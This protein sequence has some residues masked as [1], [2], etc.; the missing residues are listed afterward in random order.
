MF[1]ILDKN[2]NECFDD[3][4]SNKLKCIIDNFKTSVDQLEVICH[5]HFADIRR[6]ID[7]RR[8]TLL[9]KINRISDEMIKR[10]EQR[11]NNVKKSLTDNQL[12]D[13]NFD[14]DKENDLIE[15]YTLYCDEK[16]KELR[17]KVKSLELIK[18]NLTNDTF[19]VTHSFEKDSFGVLKLSERY[20]NLIGFSTNGANIDIWS[21]GTNSVIK[22][23]PTFT[24]EVMCLCVHDKSKLV[25]G[26]Y[27]R[28]I[29]IWDLHTGEHVKSL[30]G[31]LEQ[32]RC[33]NVLKS[34]LLASGSA[35]STIKIWNMLNMTCMHTLKGW[36]ECLEDL[37]NGQLASGSTELFV[38]IWNLGDG[39]CVR[40][41]KMYS[42]AVNCLKCLHEDR[43]AVGSWQLVLVWNYIT[44]ER[45]LTLNA[46]SDSVYGFEVFF[47]RLISCSGDKTIKVW[48]IDDEGKCIRTL[49]GHSD[50][51][52]CMQLNNDGKLYSGSHDKSLL[53]W[54]IRTG[55]C[56]HK[57][58]VDC[59]IAD[60]KL[61][62]ISEIK[63]TN[64]T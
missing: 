10:V 21:L 56:E 14:F 7:I 29:K 49:V 45:M 19:Q 24:E 28:H 3:T 52:H 17:F 34:V 42:G 40:T 32:V 54:D 55:I 50:E 31:H 1:D 60:L 6:D 36:V 37:A 61:C 47:G 63:Y 53:V 4:S 23:W 11:E 48:D 39:T 26:G 9:F 16:L 59:G 38:K 35:D 62:T 13:F 41:L 5:D 25:T 12:T 51:I 58:Q 43:L 30:I 15:H 22:K 27:D 18:Q 2:M 57:I 46:H 44:G 8:E 64:C 20:P 33:L